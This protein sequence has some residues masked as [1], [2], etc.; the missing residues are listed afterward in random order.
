MKKKRK[1]VFEKLD[2]AFTAKNYWHGITLFEVYQ[3][4]KVKHKLNE[5]SKC[6]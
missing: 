5:H 3:W 4:D 6:M 2:S 1:T